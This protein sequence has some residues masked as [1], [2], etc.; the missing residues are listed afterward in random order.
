MK[1]L[2]FFMI[3]ICFF[4]NTRTYSRNVFFR[5]VKKEEKNEPMRDDTHIKKRITIDF[6]EV[7]ELPA[8][9]REE[10]FVLRKSKVDKYPQLKIY[11][12]DYDPSGGSSSRI[13]GSIQETVPWTKSASF[14][15][16]NPYLLIVLTYAGYVN[17][18]DMH[19]QGVTIEYNSGRIL[20]ANRGLAARR[21]FRGLYK[22]QDSNGVVRVNMV[23]AYDAGFKYA[24]LDLSRSVNIESVRGNGK[25]NISHDIYS[26]PGF[27]HSAGK[28]KNNLSPADPEGWL[29]I[30]KKDVHTK[31]FIKLWRDE[32]E[33]PFSAEDLGYLIIIDPG[34]SSE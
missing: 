18:V 24:F 17:P 22:Y 10:I 31:L 6:E 26:N 29:G 13:Y 12:E 20:Q 11:P 34:N 8:M 4:A 23:N 14:F 9:S 27:Y 32:P 30:R 5:S 21:W 19:M 3:M 2:I 16:S 15:L 1:I 7:N 28:G 33:S 25:R